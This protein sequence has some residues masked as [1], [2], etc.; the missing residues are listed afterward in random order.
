MPA[1]NT[2]LKLLPEGVNAA[3][4]LFALIVESELKTA[5]AS[6]FIDESESEYLQASIT[7]IDATI[8][9]LTSLFSERFVRLHEVAF[10]EGLIFIS[11]VFAGKRHKRSHRNSGRATFLPVK[12][13][14]KCL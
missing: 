2:G 13:R 10:K 1:D 4:N 14:E 12:G 3:A 11:T 7:A 5:S 9:L 8:P 6:A